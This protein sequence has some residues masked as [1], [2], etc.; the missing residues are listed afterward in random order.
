MATCKAFL[1]DKNKSGEYKVWVK[2]THKSEWKPFS[3]GIT[4][5]PEH[6][7]SNDGRVL[8]THSSHYQ[9]NAIIH[10]LSSHLSSLANSLESKFINPTPAHVR[11][12]YDQKPFIHNRR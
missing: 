10:A 5:K 3:T 12:A 2:Y 11:Q 9:Y 6:F 8:E 4:I 7:D 1:K